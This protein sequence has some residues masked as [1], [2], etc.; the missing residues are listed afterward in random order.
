[1]RGNIPGWPLIDLRDLVKM[2]ERKRKRNTRTLKPREGFQISRKPIVHLAADDR[3]RDA[4]DSVGLPRAYGPPI[5]FAV[6]RDSRC[7]FTCWSIDWLLVFENAMPV[8]RQVYLRL[9]RADGT[10]EK[11][12]AVE[13]MAGAHY[14]STSEAHRSYRLEIGYYQ[15]AD[16]WHSVATSKEVVMPPSG[17]AETG[18]VDLVT[19]PFHL[20]FQQLVDLLGPVNDA[21]LATAIS[22]FQ[23][24][25]LSREERTR[26]SRDEKRILR[27]LDIS[28]F[29]IAAARR[30]FDAAGCK[31]LARRFGTLI[32]FSPT[33]PTRGFHGDWV[34]AGS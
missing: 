2:T 9:Y 13:P 33:S 32:A 5:L 11:I 18:D 28:L 16:I 1:L 27:R 10:E 29:D 22:Q 19:I 8:D 21:E 6:A 3:R 31:N 12:V 34:S 14:V 7:I 20:S 24:R 26:L 4:A 25:A 30:A 23:K 15:P 17:I